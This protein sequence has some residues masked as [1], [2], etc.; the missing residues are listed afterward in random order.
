MSSLKKI[1]YPIY[2]KRFRMKNFSFIYQFRFNMRIK[3]FTDGASVSLRVRIKNQIEIIFIKTKINVFVV[4]D[5]LIVKYFAYVKEIRI[6][7][8]VFYP[9]K[10]F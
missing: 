1:F 10:M 2:Q 5:N 3:F 4:I 9:Y 6:S 7:D 8:S